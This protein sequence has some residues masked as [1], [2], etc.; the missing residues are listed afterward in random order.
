MPFNIVFQNHELYILGYWRQSLYLIILCQDFIFLSWIF[1]TSIFMCILFEIEILVQFLLFLFQFLLCMECDW[2]F[3]A[4][5]SSEDNTTNTRR[6]VCLSIWS[7]HLS[8]KFFVNDKCCFCFNVCL[9]EH[10]QDSIELV[11]LLTATIL[12]FK[13]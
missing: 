7:S 2:Y 13:F 11:K 4:W 10:T 1:R 8:F 3:V 6:A 9:K 5:I 12:F